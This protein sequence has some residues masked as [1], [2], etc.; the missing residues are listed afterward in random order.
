[1]LVVGNIPVSEV[2]Q[3]LPAYSGK[4][5]IAAFNS[6]QSCTLSGESEA[7]DGLH[8]KLSTSFKNLFLHVLDVPAA[9]HSHMMEPILNPIQD[10]IGLLQEREMEVE[11]FSTV[12]GHLATEG[13]FTTGQYWAKNIG[14]AVAFEQAVKTAAAGKKHV[15]FV[16]IG[17]RRALQRNIIETVGNGT[18]VFPSVQPD[19]DYETLLTVVSKVFKLGSEVDWEEFYKG[20][21]T[22]RIPCPRYQFDSIKK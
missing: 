4:A 12:T 18:P 14:E 9:Y 11:L 10:K 16:E 2:A 20:Y 8:Q 1:M 15:V 13:D 3:F 5:C 17:P 22:L 19:K 21:E 7:I 6:P